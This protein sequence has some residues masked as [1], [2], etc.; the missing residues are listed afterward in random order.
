MTTQTWTTNVDHTTDAGFRAWGSELSSKFLAA[1]LT[2]TADTGQV[3][4]VTVLRPAINTDGGY[5][6]W[7]FNDTQQAT[8]PIF[9][10]VFYGTAGTATFPR[11]R[12]Q[13]GTASNGTGTVSG[14]GSANT[15]T[16]TANT[17][18]SAVTNYVSYLCYAPGFLG[19]SWK[20]GGTATANEHYAL[21]AI[22]RCNPRF[23]HCLL[24]KFEISHLIK[25]QSIYQIVCLLRFLAAI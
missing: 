5:E 21:F 9:I 2:Q 3:N 13:V 7:R 6:V 24:D 11:I 20:V 1:G 15:I 16:I 19:L 8:A 10:K 14:T 12:I 4:W 17:A 23:F 22:G 25:H 18:I